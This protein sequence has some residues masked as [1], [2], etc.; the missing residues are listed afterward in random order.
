MEHK[1][2]E[3]VEKEGGARRE[4]FTSLSA[5]GDKHCRNVVVVLATETEPCHRVVVRR[6]GG[7]TEASPGR[8]KQLGEASRSENGME[9]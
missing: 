2:A 3:V 5:E 6:F 7:N 9:S 8:S 4:G 1:K